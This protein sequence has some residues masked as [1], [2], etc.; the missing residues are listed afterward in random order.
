MGHHHHHHHHHHSS[1]HIEGRHM[2]AH[3][4]S[5]FQRNKILRVFNTFYD[6]NHDGVIEWDDFELAIKKICNLHS[7]P[8]DGKKHNEARATLKLIWDGLRKYADENED[9]QVTKEEWL[10]MWAE[11]VKSVEK[12]ESLPEWL[13][14]YMNFMF[15]VNDTSGDNIIDKHEYSTVY[16]SYGI[17]KSDCDA[18]FDTLSDGG[19]TMV[20]REIFARL[21][22]EYFVSNDR[23]AKG[24]HLFG[25]LKL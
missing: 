1:G 6:C 21:W 18:A 15:D 13:T 14:K 10:K 22:T 25:D 2:A 19:K 24:N 23:G 3:Q 4:L 5:D 7:W 11:C 17:P 20:T 16:M 8:T 12:G 9:E